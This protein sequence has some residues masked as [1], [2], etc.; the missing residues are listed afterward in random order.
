M[1]PLEN[2]VHTSCRLETEYKNS[3]WICDF[4]VPLLW[5]W[6]VLSEELNG[7]TCGK[8]PSQVF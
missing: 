2:A 1:A 4:V 7:W 5:L 8:I 6:H 3:S